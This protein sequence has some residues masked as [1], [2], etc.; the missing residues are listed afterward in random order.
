MDLWLV[1]DTIR[2]SKMRDVPGASAVR[3]ARIRERFDLSGV[4]R[5]REAVRSGRGTGW[6]GGRRSGRCAGGQA[7]RGACYNSHN[8]SFAG[9]RGAAGQA[10]EGRRALLGMEA[11]LSSTPRSKRIISS[12]RRMCTCDSPLRDKCTS[13]WRVDAGSTNGPSGHSKRAGPRAHFGD[14]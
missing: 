8:P 5:P 10:G 13:I 7:E 12:A 14:R 9:N 3:G 6:E 1:N 11:A 2:R 4:C